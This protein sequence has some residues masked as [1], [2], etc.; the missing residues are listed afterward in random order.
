MKLTF[1]LPAPLLFAKERANLGR[2]FWCERLQL[3]AEARFK[4]SCGLL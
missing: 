4:A 3:P 1:S 2:T